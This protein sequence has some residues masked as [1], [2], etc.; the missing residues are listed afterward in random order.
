MLGGLGQFDGCFYHF[1][2]TMQG[3]EIA[4]LKGIDLAG[5]KFEDSQDLIVANDGQ[6]RYGGDAE[7]AAAFT[8]H[9]RIAIGII[10][11]QRQARAHA[12]AGEPEFGG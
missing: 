3:R 8:I 6:H 5:K 4:L 10:A 7:L 1:T 2:E 12:F 9:T 11:A